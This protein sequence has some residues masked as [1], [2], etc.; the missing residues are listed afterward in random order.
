MRATYWQ[1][2]LTTTGLEATLSTAGRAGVVA[3]SGVDVDV[4]DSIIHNIKGDYTNGDWL[5]AL[6]VEPASY[7]TVAQLCLTVDHQPSLSSLETTV[8]KLRRCPAPATVVHKSFLATLKQTTYKVVTKSLTVC[9]SLGICI[10]MQFSANSR[11]GQKFYLLPTSRLLGLPIALLSSPPPRLLG[12][13][14]G[15]RDSRQVSFV[16]Y[17]T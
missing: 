2:L 15:A 7:L 11:V 16:A 13:G 14:A 10:E 4:G 17:C 6:R 3:S 1:C 9:G 8:T 12:Y 5:C